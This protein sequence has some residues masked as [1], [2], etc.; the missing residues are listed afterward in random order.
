MK[1]RQILL[2]PAFF[3][4]LSAHAANE[5]GFRETFALAE[6]RA[7]A[8]KQLIPGTRDYYVYHALHYQTVGDEKAYREIMTQAAKRHGR[9]PWM[10]EL[11]NRQALLNYEK[12]PKAALDHIRNRL[13]LRFD[14]RRE[15]DDATS[16]LP[17]R[18]DPDRISTET[19]KADALR[20]RNNLHKFTDAG[21]KLLADEK[22]NPVQR[23]QL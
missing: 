9:T 23:R 3:A 16:S 11:E 6:A 2:L 13:N 19:F 1:I 15:Q 10:N 8:L 12:E 21:L 18:L 7:A 17:T 14:H 5:I 4:V 22:L 20:H